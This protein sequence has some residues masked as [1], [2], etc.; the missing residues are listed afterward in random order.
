MAPGDGSLA[1]RCSVAD[2]DLVPVTADLPDPV[3]ASLGLSAVAAWMALTWRAGLQAGERVVVLG[4]GG[5]VGQVALGAAR[6]LGA[7]RVVGVCRRGPSTARARRAGADAVV[8]LTGDA[9]A[10]ATRLAD[11]CDGAVDVVVDP[12]FGVAATAAAQVLAPG[13]RLVNLGGAA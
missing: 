7:S 10:L 4:A 11:A 3:V 12:V 1:E 2:A 8:E 5:A 9:G 13:G 6:W